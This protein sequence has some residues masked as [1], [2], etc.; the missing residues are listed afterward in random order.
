MHALKKHDDSA[1]DYDLNEMHT[2]VW[3]HIGNLSVCI[4]ETDEGVAANIW[5][6]PAA[7]AQGPLTS[8]YAFFTEA[9]DG[10]S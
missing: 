2:C 9:E 3:I 1:N 5:P 10:E 4:H 8:T 7:D 6:R